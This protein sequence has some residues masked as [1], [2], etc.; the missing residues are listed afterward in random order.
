MRTDKEKGGRVDQNATT[1]NIGL[2]G[3]DAEINVSASTPRQPAVDQL[4]AYEASN[5]ELIPL[6]GP[7][8]VNRKGQ[9][10]GK[11]PI[12]QWRKEPAMSLTEAID[13]R[14]IGKNIGVRLRPTD[15]VIDVDPRNFGEG[16]NPLADLF[17]MIGEE[18][19]DYPTV[20]TGSGGL[21]IYMTL[22]QPIQVLNELPDFKGVEFKA[23]GR[24]VVAAGSIHPDTGKPYLWDVLAIPLDNG[25]PEAPRALIELIRKPVSEQSQAEAGDVEPERLAEMLGALTVEDYRDQNEWLNLMMACHHAT[26]GDGLLEFIEWSTSDPDYAEHSEVIR[27]RWNSL[28]CDGPGGKVTQGF[29]FKRINEAGRGDLVPR[30]S[31][32]EDFADIDCDDDAGRFE[33]PVEGSKAW[34]DEWVWISDIVRFVRRSDLKK[35]DEKQFKS[36]YQHRWPDGDICNA[37]WKQKLPMRR[38]ES[39]AYVPSQREI[40]TEGEWKGRYNLWRPGGVEPEAG[41]VSVFLEHMAYLFPDEQEREH[42]LDYLSFLV[43]PE[44]VK[45]HFALLIQGKPGTG[46]SFLSKLMRA[47]I[48]ENNVSTPL[49]SEVTEKYTGWQEGVQLAILEE[50]M[51]LGRKEVSNTLKPVITDDYLRIRLMHTNTYSQPNFLNLLCIS[52]HKDALPIEIGD[53][54]WLVVFS[55]SEPQ[56]EAYYDRLFGLL[57]EKHVAAIKYYLQNREVKLNPKGVAPRTKGKAEMQHLSLGEVEQVLDEMLEDRAEPFDF[58]LVRVADVIEALPYGLRSHKGL[59]NRVPSWLRDVAGAKEQ[60]RYKKQDGSGR[61]SWQLWSIDNHAEWEAKGAAGCIDAFMEKRG[62]T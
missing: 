42:V 11:A 36:M 26:G 4:Q 35:H 34:W 32:K 16:V 52:N 30:P 59:R 17:E 38:F 47:M 15:L 48:G 7:D 50:L 49:S 29:L 58:D 1:H 51:A 41:D 62:E 18:F 12:G 23:H 40:I 20:M 8:E 3:T 19:E 46:K 24:Q 61:K 28:S 5:A 39:L 14:T 55:E 37:V 31:A 60:K 25:A 33:K 45:V 57:K 27:N 21:H 53:R 44:F 6:H 13:H 22:P 2:E 9:K 43:A 54:R 10:L 56:D